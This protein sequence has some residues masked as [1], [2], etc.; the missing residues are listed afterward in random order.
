MTRHLYQFDADAVAGDGAAAVARVPGDPSRIGVVRN[1]R[2]RHNVER[3]SSATP[4]TGIK[5]ALPDGR[6][7]MAPALA[8][9][10]R[11]GLDLLVIDGGDGTVRD[12][13]TLGQSVFGD[14]WPTL[15]VLPKGKTNALTL[16]LGVPDDWRLPDA[17]AAYARGGRVVRRPIRVTSLDRP[18]VPPVVGFIFGAGSFTQAIRR[19]QD[20][21]S[22][23]L[24]N[25]L[26]VGMTSAW[27]LVKAFLGTGDS[28]WRKGSPM[29]FA[30]DPDGRP[31]P[32][33]RHGDPAYRSIA[34][35]T[36]LERLPMDAKPLGPPRPG[37]KLGIMDLPLRRILLTFP[38]ILTG[39]LPAW[40]AEAGYRVHDVAGFELEIGDPFI[41]D[42]E[43][44]PAGRYRVKPGAP[45]TFVTA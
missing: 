8:E 39:R 35:A 36:T 10:A 22:L 28:P 32:R 25:N 13:L 1:P 24:F 23:G 44:F 11:D 4:E 38:L 43:L 16:D 27:G 19:A 5:L 3:P 14:A 29:A 6:S 40:L 2:S 7:A 21:H 20:A 41:I 33:S 34:L 42:G 12:V 26:A 31:A 15:A 45:L 18:E 30:L 9:L 17:L 37:L